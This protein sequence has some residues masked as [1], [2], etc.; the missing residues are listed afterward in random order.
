MEK[1]KIDIK[2]ILIIT[3]LLIIPLFLSVYIRTQ[4]NKLE[5]LDEIARD[6]VHAQLRREAESQVNQQYPNLPAQNKNTEVERILQERISTQQN[7]IDVAVVQTANSMRERFKDENGYTY[8][9]DID[10]YFW[11]R[12][13]DNIVKNG[14]IGDELRDGKS[15]DNHM[16]A[17]GG[18]PVSLTFYPWFE[19]QLYKTLIVFNKGMTMMQTAFL[20]PLFLSFFAIVAAFFIGKKISNNVGGFVAAIMIAS[21]HTIITRTLGSDNDIINIVFPLIILLTFLIAFDAKNIWKR[22]GFTVLTSVLIGFYSFAWG[23][24]WYILMFLI[25]TIV[26]FIG[27]KLLTNLLEFKDF[28]KIFNEEVKSLL[29]FLGIFLGATFICLSFFQ[30]VEDLANLPLIPFSLFQNLKRAAKG[31]GS[32]NYFPNIYTTVAELNASSLPQIVE[33]VGAGAMAL[34]LMGIIISLCKF[35]KD[36]LIYTIYFG[37]SFVWYLF[38]VNN[39]GGLSTISFLIFM[40]IPII[41]G[42]LIS[43][44]KKY[45]VDIKYALLLTIWFAA[46][47]Y[48]SSNGVRFI[49]MIMPPFII[50]LALFMGRVFDLL[51]NTIPEMLSMNKLFIQ[52]PA[53]VLI[54][55]FLLSPIQG[56][57]NAG[58]KYVP[59]F[60]DAWHNTL[61]KIKYESQPDAIITSWWDFGHWFKAISDRAVTFDGASQNEPT[62]FWVGKLLLTQDEDEALGILR[63][64]DCSANKAFNEI[65]EETKDSPGTIDLILQIVRLD[66]AQ[67]REVLFDK[68]SDPD[69]VLEYT[70]CDNPPEAFLITSED[71]VGKAGVWAHFGSWDFNRAKLHYEFQTKEMQGFITNLIDNYSYSERD[72]QQTFYDIS[73]LSSDRAVNDWIAPWPSYAG[74]TQCPKSE[75]SIMCTL[76]L[77]GQKTYANINVTTLESNI[78]I[79]GQLLHLNSIGFFNGTD[80][81][82]K[83]SSNDNIGISGSLVHENGAYFMVFS[84]PELV[85]STFSRLFFM[86]GQGME[87]FDLF[88]VQASVTGVR[89]YTWRIDWTGK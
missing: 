40:V 53:L 16:V 49:F 66:K 76:D 1:K 52:I 26:A 50:S 28:K 36:K 55:L 7:E 21:H 73:S 60:S 48:A 17:P 18:Y 75:D 32:G 84:T 39:V 85:G 87:H 82:I 5:F 89:I 44:I 67:A 64:L 43:I 11:M 15:W 2:N 34:A 8:L 80:Y 29:I 68:V 6:N 45:D 63:M 3:L 19:A 24:Y 30:P 81:I 12:Y 42:V 23:G 79:N 54:F 65:F 25:G 27:Y 22:V 88:N 74:V 83:E 20:T 33:F 31:A 13:A 72:A 51:S 61:T 38:L 4:P 14:H 47:I 78:A 70:H 58:N 37:L 71:M 10:S 56:G 86:G 57:I 9:G 59:N 77:G 69:K 41:A 46:T 62:A 35:A